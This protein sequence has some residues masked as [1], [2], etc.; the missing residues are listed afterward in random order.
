M[1]LPSALADRERRSLSVTLFRESLAML[2]GQQRDKDDC[3]IWVMKEYGVPES[4]TKLFSFRLDW[5]VYPKRTLGFMKHNEVLVSTIDNR[6]LSY[7]IGT[8]ASVDTGIR[9]HPSSF[10]FEPFVESLVLVENKNASR[11]ANPFPVLILSLLFTLKRLPSGCSV[12]DGAK[13]LKLI[14]GSN[15]SSLNLEPMN[16][17]V[18]LAFNTEVEGMGKIVMNGFKPELV[19]VYTEL[20]NEFVV[21]DRWF[22]FV[23]ASTQPNRF[24]VHSATS[25]AS[26]ATAEKI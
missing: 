5:P 20:A 21:F 11:S 26:P 19:P 8:K 14:L 23:P 16:S 7:D 13:R 24:Y 3:C 10:H 2:C 22:A 18:Q 9:G 4:W 6:L 12:F 15:N 25:T 1:I 17:F